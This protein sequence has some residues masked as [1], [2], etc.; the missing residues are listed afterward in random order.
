LCKGRYWY[1]INVI[2]QFSSHQ[3]D[4][5]LSWNGVCK[6]GYWVM[7]F[8]A[9]LSNISVISW[10]WV[11]LVEYTWVPRENHHLPKVNDKLYHIKLYR[12]Q[13][14]WAIFEL[15]TLEV[16]GTNCICSCKSN[17]YTITIKTIPL[18][19]KNEWMSVLYIITLTVLLFVFLVRFLFLWIY[20]FY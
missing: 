5:S 18:L 4:R 1:A 10:R 7:V 6:L 20:L 17:Y 19:E 15:T 12:L 3:Y 2:L 9:T 16:I 11:L 8:N 14:V 13:L